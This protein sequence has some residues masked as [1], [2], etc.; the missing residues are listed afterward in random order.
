MYRIGKD[1][2]CFTFSHLPQEGIEGWDVYVYRMD[3]WALRMYCTVYNH[4]DKNHIL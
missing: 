1:W 2:I 4:D 3:V